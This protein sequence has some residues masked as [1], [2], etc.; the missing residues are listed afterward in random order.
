MAL[1]LEEAKRQQAIVAAINKDPSSLSGLSI[2]GGGDTYDRATHTADGISRGS[3]DDL[4]PRLR[5]EGMSDDQIADELG[6]M[7][8]YPFSS[9]VDWG[10]EAPRDG[11]LVP[12]GAPGGSGQNPYNPD[13]PYI[14]QNPN[15]PPIE[16]DPSGT[17]SLN[18][19]T[20][21]DTSWDWT[22]NP[23]A[24]VQGPE[25]IDNYNLNYA[26]GADSP[27]GLPGAAPGNNQDF[28]AQQ[29]NNLLAEQQAGKGAAIGAAIKRQFADSQP[30]PETSVDPWAWAYGGQGLPDGAPWASQQA[31][32]L[33]IAQQ[34]ALDP[35]AQQDQGSTNPLQDAA[36]FG[37][38]I[39]LS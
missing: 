36:N 14:P 20:P 28:Y 23:D 37:L 27:W 33:S 22:Q 32:P 17:G 38:S 34:P 21:V 9:N 13:A 11:V 12:G 18:G 29:F 15:L 31:P 26:P 1:S 6:R 5:A 24:G 7:G 35:N 8:M 19:Q 25:P 4:W 10:D 2:L 16:W 3:V 39:A 30:P